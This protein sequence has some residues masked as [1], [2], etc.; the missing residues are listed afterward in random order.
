MQIVLY[1]EF[2][3]LNEYVDAERSFR[4]NAANLKKFE[5]QRVKLESIGVLPIPPEAYPVSISFTWYCKD[6]KKDPDNICFARKF[7]LDGLQ[8]AKILTGDGWKHIKHFSDDFYVDADDPRVV[9]DIT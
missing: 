7:I 2:T 1:G 6:K 5:T 9:L 4:M 3:S 8:E